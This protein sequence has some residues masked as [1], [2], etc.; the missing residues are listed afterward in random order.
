MQ[1]QVTES[2]VGAIA[3]AIEKA[4]ID[5]AKRK[6]TDSLDAYNLYLRG[7]SKLYQ[8]DNRQ[9]VEEALRR[10]VATHRRQQAI[11]DMAGLG[12][13][14]DLDAMRTGQTGRKMG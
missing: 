8:L 11:E 3:P 4:E 14:G 2:V 12:W 13:E 1:D 9:S 6:P 5:R 7:L 10:V